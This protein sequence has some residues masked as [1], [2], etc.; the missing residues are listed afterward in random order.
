MAMDEVKNRGKASTFLYEP[1][2]HYI[3]SLFICMENDIEKLKTQ[4]FFFVKTQARA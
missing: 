1:R 4:A 3:L 2:P